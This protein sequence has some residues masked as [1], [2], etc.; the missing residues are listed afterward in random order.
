VG[1]LH[2]W[3]AHR[4]A[5]WPVMRTARKL[6]PAGAVVQATIATS[7]AAVLSCERLQQPARVADRLIG[8]IAAIAAGPPVDH[9]ARAA[10]ALGIK[11]VSVGASGSTASADS[12]RAVAIGTDPRK[13]GRRSRQQWPHDDA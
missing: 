1:Q 7:S 3:V 2:E 10:W 9:Q 8:G 11:I 13:E 5:G 12:P 4:V 6:Q